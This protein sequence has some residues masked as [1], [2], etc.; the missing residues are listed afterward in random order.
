MLDGIPASGKGK[1]EEKLGQRMGE[2]RGTYLTGQVAIEW[3]AAEVV[4]WA[5]GHPDRERC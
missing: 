2:D 5:V 4:A 1:Q 3:R